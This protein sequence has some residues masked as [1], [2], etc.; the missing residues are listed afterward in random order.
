MTWRFVDGRAS[1]CPTPAPRSSS[2]R[3]WAR[4]TALSSSPRPPGPLRGLTRSIDE[5]E[6]S[7]WFTG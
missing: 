3:R 6:L 1:A 2:P 5:M 7:S 4:R